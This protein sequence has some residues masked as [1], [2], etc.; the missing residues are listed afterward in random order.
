M[1]LR[2]SLFGYSMLHCMYSSWPRFCVDSSV[3]FHATPL[4]LRGC[5]CRLV[6]PGFVPKEFVSCSWSCFAQ[7]VQ[8]PVICY[9]GEL[10]IP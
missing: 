7:R 4:K 8:V 3:L 10:S 1:N 5:P 6:P 9:G 2:H